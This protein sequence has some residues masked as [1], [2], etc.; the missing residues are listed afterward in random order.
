[1]FRSLRIFVIVL[2]IFPAGCGSGGNS[3]LSDTLSRAVTEKKISQRKVESIMKE[4]EML[5]EKDGE[6]AR[7][8]ADQIITAVEMGGDSSHIDAVRRLVA[9]KNGK[10]KV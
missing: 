10:V 8:Y 5:R 3:K 4:Y 7:K 1:M 6:I 9:G 2:L